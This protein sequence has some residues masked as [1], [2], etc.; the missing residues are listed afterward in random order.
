MDSGS[1]GRAKAPHPVHSGNRPPVPDP[2]PRTMVAGMKSRLTLTLAIAAFA[3]CQSGGSKPAGGGSGGAMRADLEKICNAKKLSGADQDPS[4]QGTY[5]MAQ[6]L[7]TNV[8]S[9]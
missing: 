1:S 7:N 5:V 6:W 9:D 4:G 8:T 3:A 2:R